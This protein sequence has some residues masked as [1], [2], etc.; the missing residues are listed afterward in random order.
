[1]CTV[2][3]LPAALLASASDSLLLR[4]VCNRDEH[5]TRAPALPPTVWAAGARRALMPIDPSSGG[6]WIAANDAGL[7]FAVLNTYKGSGA[8]TG[9]VS[10]VDSLN[11]A[12]CQV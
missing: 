5:L 6:T 9:D 11:A 7:V 1:M 10:H 12:S 2:T 4:V 8:H 3:A